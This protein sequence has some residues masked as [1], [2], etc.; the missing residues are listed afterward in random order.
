M[1]IGTVAFGRGDL[2]CSWYLHFSI[3]WKIADAIVGNGGTANVEKA[4]NV[5]IGVTEFAKLLRFA[6]EHDVNLVVPGPE[7]PLVEGVETCFRKG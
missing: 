7:V 1:E 2:R 3:A 6:Q 4:K 5:D